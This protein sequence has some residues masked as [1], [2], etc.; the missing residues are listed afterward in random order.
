MPLSK[1]VNFTNSVK[2]GRKVQKH[3]TPN[4][5]AP[6]FST[7]SNADMSVF[8]IVCNTMHG[9]IYL[10]RNHLGNNHKYVTLDRNSTGTC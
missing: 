3:K 4:K 2:L 1:P 6:L 10:I 7:L 9:L 8:H 5:R